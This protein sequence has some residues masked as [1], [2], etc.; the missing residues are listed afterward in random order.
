MHAAIYVRVSTDEQ[1]QHGFSLA[2]QKETCR[3]RATALKVSTIKEFTDEGI[4]GTTLDRLGLTQ[5]RKAVNCGEVDTLILRDPDRLSR[6]LAHQLLLSE[7]FEKAGV[8]LEFIDFAWQDTPEGRL[9]YSIRGAIAEFEREKIRDRMVRGKMQKARQGGLPMGFYAYGYTHNLEKGD[10]IINED[11]A[12]VVRKI[13]NLFIYKDTGI[14]GVAKWL[15]KEEV[16]TKKGRFKWHRQVVRQILRNPVYKG[17]W[18]YKDIIIPVPSIIENETW[19]K[20]REKLDKARRLWAGNPQNKYLLS[21]IIT[22]PDCGNTMNGIC[23]N[24]WG[25]KVR[26]YTCRKNC[27]GAKNTGCQPQKML[28]AE[29]IEKAVWKQVCSWLQNPDTIIE[30]IM[31]MSHEGNSLQKEL[32]MIQKHL[33]DVDKGQET[34]M[35]ALSSGLI[36]LDD[37]IKNN[38]EQL[39][40]R[41]ERLKQREEKLTS[42]L[43][44][45]HKTAEKEVYLKNIT[46]E[47]LS[48]LD[49]LDFIEKKSL[50]RIL[51]SQVV[52]SG[53]NVREGKKSNNINITII[54]KLPGTKNMS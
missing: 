51:I 7:E 26:C 31:H 49:T 45:M 28:P 17:E 38:L 53:G 43:Q 2:E 18:H 15:N 21:G 9:F 54:A 37:K 6:K 50:V 24:W 8:K 19:Y 14:N 10:I 29:P 42:N 47:L 35:G 41:K 46:R 39:K 32:Q 25:E 44:I 3:A 1:V 40:R 48:Q 20:A 23:P 11:E 12:A 33:A 5:L 16:P 4:S 36:E 52:I 13:F 34:I 30:K 27:Q 22:C